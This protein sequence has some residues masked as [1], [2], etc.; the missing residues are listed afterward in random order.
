[1]FEFPL[2]S[3]HYSKWTKYMLS[4]YLIRSRECYPT[5]SY[6]QRLH[7]SSH[8]PTYLHILTLIYSCKCI[9][10]ILISYTLI[11]PGFNVDEDGHSK[12][13]PTQ[14]RYV[15]SYGALLL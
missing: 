2:F 4:K 14:P 5:L 3:S 12:S 6:Y 13:A 15:E 8:L 9:Q 1:M 7:L 10:Y 11:P